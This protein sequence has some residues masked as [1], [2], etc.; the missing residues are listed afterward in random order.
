MK[1]SGVILFDKNIDRRTFFAEVKEC[2]N[3]KKRKNRYLLTEEKCDHLEEVLQKFIIAQ[4]YRTVK[5]TVKLILILNVMCRF[6]FVS[7]KYLS[8][9]TT[10]L[11]NCLLQYFLPI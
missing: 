7:K 9:F 5:A 3:D 2:A 8:A 10:F 6:F 4:R 11:Q 1:K